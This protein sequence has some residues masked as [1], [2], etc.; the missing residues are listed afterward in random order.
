MLFRSPYESMELIRVVN[1]RIIAKELG[2]EK[3]M[4]KNGKLYLYFLSNNNEAYF[5][6][7]EFGALLMYLQNYPRETQIK[8]NKNKRYLLI[9]NVTTIEKA[10][11]VLMKVKEF[12]NE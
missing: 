3:V 12:I 5:Q 8:E 2:I 10:L 4:L 7:P 11:S 1:L 6:S 9:E